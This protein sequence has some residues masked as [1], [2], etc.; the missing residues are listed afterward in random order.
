MN[1]HDFSS[2][3]LA[4]SILAQGHGEPSNQ[5]L[6]AFHLHCAHHPY[7]P[8]L[9]PFEDKVC[10]IYFD[11]FYS[12]TSKWYYCKPCQFRIILSR[13]NTINNIKTFHHKRNSADIINKFEV[14]WFCG[15]NCIINLNLSERTYKIK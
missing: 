13:V 12:N 10:N 5:N 4:V 6:F 15:C 7:H 8:Q 2:P 3:F 14:N 1:I 11:V 9:F